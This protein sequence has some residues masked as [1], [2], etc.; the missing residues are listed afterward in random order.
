M[1]AF[2][3]ASTYWTHVEISMEAIAAHTKK[4]VSSLPL[5]DQQFISSPF[6]KSDFHLF[7]SHC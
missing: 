7:S 4:N 5:N 2:T 3:L 1:S 6:P